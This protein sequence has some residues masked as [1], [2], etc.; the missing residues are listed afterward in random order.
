MPWNPASLVQLAASLEAA[1][2]LFERNRSKVAEAAKRYQQFVDD[3]EQSPLVLEAKFRL[4]QSQNYIKHD[5]FGPRG[6]DD[7]GRFGVDS[8]NLPA[9]SGDGCA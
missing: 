8:A 3:H 2:Q 4:G 1:G 9:V 6:Y 7:V 5:G